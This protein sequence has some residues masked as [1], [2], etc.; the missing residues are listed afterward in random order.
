[1]TPLTNFFDRACIVFIRLQ[2]LKAHKTHEQ[3]LPCY[4]LKAGPHE[5]T[6][7]GAEFAHGTG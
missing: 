3:A 5:R 2:S 1:M 4:G 7:L 6:A